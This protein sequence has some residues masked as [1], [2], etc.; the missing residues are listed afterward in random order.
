MQPITTDETK[1]ILE[2]QQFD[3]LISVLQQRGYTTIGPTI[4]DN[5]VV[6]DEILTSNNLPVG[7]TDE[8]ERGTYRLKKRNDD[9][10]FGY[11]VG[12][13]SWKKYLFPPHLKLF[14]AKKNGNEFD[15]STSLN[16]TNDSQAAKLAFIGVRA[17]EINAMLIQDKVFNNGQ[18]VEPYYKSV[19][20]NIFIVAVNCGQAA[21]TCFC[22]SMKTGPRAENNFDI[23]LTEIVN[24]KEHY[25]IIE[26]GSEKGK[27]LVNEIP[28]RI[29][30]QKEIDKAKHIIENTAKQIQR[31]LDTTNIKQ[32]LYDNFDHP[33]WEE[34]ATRCLNCANCTMVCP[35]C[36]CST[37]EDVSDLTGDNAERWRTWDSCF[38]MD[39]SYIHGGSLRFS[40]KAR[41]RQWLTH[42]LASWHDQFGTSGCVGCGRCITWC[43]VGI[44]LTEEVKAFQHK[45]K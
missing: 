18:F 29:A 36:F 9:A 45:K 26:T 25:F 34:I 17:C 7:W 14:S 32:L 4:Q 28:N 44:D 38:T 33:H 30:E 40:G 35:T 37:M 1:Q 43:P 27:T 20:E 22:A 8:Q 41:Y 12:P 39:H 3:S 42:K 10:L 15:I 5:A 13:Q 6:Y 2:R 24:E 11:V 21:S 31:T 23:A 16:A 19:R